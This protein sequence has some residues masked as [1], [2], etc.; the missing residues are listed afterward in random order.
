MRLTVPDGRLVEVQFAVTA[1]EK[2]N[3]SAAGRGE[4]WQALVLARRWTGLQAD[5]AVGAPWDSPSVPIGSL[6]TLPI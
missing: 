5:E 1:G 4:H 6:P 3:G 2:Q